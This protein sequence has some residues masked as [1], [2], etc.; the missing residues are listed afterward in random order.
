MKNKIGIMGGTFNPIHNGHIKLA[1]C[2]LEQYGLSHVIFIPDNVAYH[3]NESDMA[4]AD[5]RYEM[6]RLAI[7]GNERFSV[8]DIDIKRAGSTYTYETLHELKM[9]MPNDSFY[10]IIGADSLF[11][12]DTW[13]NPDI[14]SKE[15]TILAAAR[16]DA[17]K[18][19][20][21]DKIVELKSK[22]D[23]DIRLIDFEKIDISST[24]I[25]NRIRSGD[26]E[27]CRSR[28]PRRTLDFIISNS[29]Y[30]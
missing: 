10:F 25:R 5:M 9:M 29:L 19:D 11:M 7:E 4:S 12:F 23:S 6:T 21:T 30:E 22:F 26:I 1:E 17:E 16:D 3:K 15:C 24:E 2:A 18:S 14:I 28:I 27:W 8:S 20:M 13:K